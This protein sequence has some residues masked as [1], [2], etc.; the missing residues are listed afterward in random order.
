[1]AEWTW[2]EVLRHPKYKALPDRKKLELERAYIDWALQQA[3]QSTQDQREE[4]IKRVIGSRERL[5]GSILPE[6]ISS[7]C[8]AP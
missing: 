4:F 5:Y 2:E 8:V 7:G 6:H 3:P 1:M